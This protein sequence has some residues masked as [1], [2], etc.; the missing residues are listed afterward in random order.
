MTKARVS[1]HFGEWLQGRL[2][3]GGPVVLVTVACAALN[4]RIGFGSAPSIFSPQ[5][6]DRFW[7]TLGLA[8]TAVPAL[9]YD[10][11]LGA[12][13]GASTATL[14]SYARHAGFDGPVDRLIK[15]CLAVEGASDPLMW[16]EPDSLLWASREGRI[17]TRFKRPPSCTILGGFWGAPQRTNPADSNFADISDLVDA[18]ETHADAG[19]LAGLAS[20]ASQSA[21]RCTARHG[22][23]GP[24]DP[25][26]DL[27]KSLGA[28]G[29][30]RA[31]TGSARGL[32]FPPGS[33]PEYGRAAL[34]EA[35]LTEA[36]TF[37]AGAS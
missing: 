34:T 23:Q 11:P 1:G 24:A 29:H 30:L 4:V 26:P 14:I 6:L 16:P 10:M 5:Q 3:P 35:G 27:A 19:N 33:A 22:A 37:L 36:F 15:A 7:E 18:W 13:C 20:L 8:P 9:V 21:R 17:V 28:L 12:G 25:L 31:H 32:V 2:G